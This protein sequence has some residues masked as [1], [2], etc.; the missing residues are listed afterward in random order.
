MSNKT[1]KIVYLAYGILLSIVLVVSGILLMISCYN[2]YSLGDRPFTPESISAAFSKIQVILYVTIGGIAVG[3]LLKV[4]L[5]LDE[6]KIKANIAPI[7]ALKRLEDKYDISACE[8]EDIATYKKAKTLRLVCKIVAIVLCS[9]LSLP[10]LIIALLPSSY[11]M[12]YNP[13]VVNL[14][15]LIIPS[16]IVCALIA[17]AYV[18][19]NDILVNTQISSLKALIAD[20]KAQKI[21]KSECT[22]CQARKERYK[23]TS[24]RI[25]IAAVALIFIVLGI[26][27]GGMADVLSKAINIC[28]EC[29]GLG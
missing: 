12:D 21:E 29:I 2:I 24:A 13:S 25:I 5:P 16:F 1:K 11:T 6:P 26:F 28:T 15:Y 9:I 27:N 20:G 14:C 3:G 23:I 18:L 7:T 19:S 4:I 10:A 8:K 22:A 17:L